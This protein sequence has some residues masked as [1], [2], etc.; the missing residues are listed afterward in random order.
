VDYEL[1]IKIVTL[2]IGAIGAAKLFNDLSVSKVSRMRDEYKFAKDFLSDINSG[3]ISH[4]FLLDKGYQAIAGDK[5]VEAE[6][7]AYLLSLQNPELAIRDYT[8]GRR[9]LEHLPRNGN[10]E[11]EFKKRYKGK[12]PRFWRKSFYLVSYMGLVFLAFAPLIC[13]EL[14]KDLTQIFITFALSLT[15]F[16]TYAWSTLKAAIRI[17]RAED[18]VLRQ[19]KHTQK[20]LLSSSNLSLHSDE[21]APHVRR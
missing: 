13:N 10:L 21:N 14:F 5:F 4:P 16:G 8:F 6:E 17:F 15:V 2:G 19:H 20:I 7:V 3:A 12:W 9:Y 1:P 11:I 18:L